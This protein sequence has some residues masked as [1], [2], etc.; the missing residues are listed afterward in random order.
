V[1]FTEEYDE[2]S[3]RA[4]LDA[5]DDDMNTP[6]AYTVIFDTVKKLNQAT[7]SRDVDWEM[8]GRL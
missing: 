1:V 5:L 4:F 3:Y 8:V 6:N 2:E 7:R